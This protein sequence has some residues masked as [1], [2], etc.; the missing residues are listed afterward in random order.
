M[1]PKIFPRHIWKTVIVPHLLVRDFS[2]KI[3]GLKKKLEQKT[4]YVKDD[5]FFSPARSTSRL[6]R[7]T[8]RLKRLKPRLKR[9][10]PR[11]INKMITLYVIEKLFTSS[12]PAQEDSNGKKFGCNHT[13]KN[14]SGFSTTTHEKKMSVLIPKNKYT[15]A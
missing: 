5:T 10:K 15:R 1:Q 7:S 12:I 2:K 13:C 4:S 14:K 6:S 11:L 8:S 3:G 9:L